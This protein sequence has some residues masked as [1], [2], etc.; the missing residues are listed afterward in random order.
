MAAIGFKDEAVQH[1][2]FLLTLLDDGKSFARETDGSYSLTFAADAQR[3]YEHGLLTET[4]Y[5]QLVGRHRRR[6]LDAGFE[7]LDLHGNHLLLAL[8]PDGV[9]K[10]DKHG[11]IFVA[12]CSF[13]LIRRSEIRPQRLGES[14][15]I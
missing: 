11:Q 4:E 12:H 6:L 10:R 9:F 13:D 15:D 1:T 14:P 7:P 3:A 2:Q 5:R 8:D